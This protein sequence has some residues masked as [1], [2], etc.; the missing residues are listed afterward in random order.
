MN[1]PLI[2][3]KKLNGEELVADLTKLPHLLIGGL[4]GSG[5]SNLII[6]IIDE[7]AARKSPDEVKFLLIDPKMVELNNLAKRVKDHVYQPVETEPGVPYTNFNDA[8]AA[9]SGLC[10]ELSSRYDLLRESHCRSIEEYN[11]KNEVKI[12]YIILVIDEYADL[13]LMTDDFDFVEDD[14][15]DNQIEEDEDFEHGFSFTTNVLRLA[16]AGRAVGIHI[17]LSTQ[18]P[19]SYIVN[20]IIKA[21]FPARIAFKVNQK[22]DS[23]V[24]I[25]RPGAELLS[26]PGDFIWSACGELDFAH[27]PL[28]KD[29]QQ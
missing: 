24:L 11:R 15:C 18:R 6:N 21:S 5:K 1:I 3:G 12:P 19:S 14:D 22:K 27:A 13:I 16:Q 7:L 23:Q 29:C 17:M 25:D 26:S 8:C 10:T 2:L 4:P 20:G 28:A 9:I